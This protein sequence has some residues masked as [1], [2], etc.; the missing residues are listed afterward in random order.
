V[1]GS[2]QDRLLNPNT[3]FKRKRA[4]VYRTREGHQNESSIL[5]LRGTGRFKKA[6]GS[7]ASLTLFL[8]QKN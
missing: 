7:E 2:L 6:S 8:L 3:N 5:V 1:T 4:S